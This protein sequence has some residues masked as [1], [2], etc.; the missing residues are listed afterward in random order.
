MDEIKCISCGNYIPFN[1]GGI[2]D[3]TLETVT[4]NAP[5]RCPYCGLHYLKKATLEINFGFIEE[6]ENIDKI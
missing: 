2:H 6:I 5:L 1:Q 4:L 3:C